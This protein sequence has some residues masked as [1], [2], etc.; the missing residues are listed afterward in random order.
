MG[1]RGKPRS[2]T[3]PPELVNEVLLGAAAKL[4][5]V[6]LRPGLVEEDQTSGIDEGL[7]G[8]PARAVAAYVRAIPLPCDE[9]LF[10]TL[11]QVRLSAFLTCSTRSDPRTPKPQ[12]RIFQFGFRCPVAK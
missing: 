1:R 2:S 10:K 9:G 5:H 11:R 3:C 12:T 8:A 6:G 4:C 7:T